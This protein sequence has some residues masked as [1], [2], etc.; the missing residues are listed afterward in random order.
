MGNTDFKNLKKRSATSIENLK[1]QVDKL[2]TKKD[3]GD[4][5][6]W[7]PK[8]DANGNAFT[9]IR[10]L[11]APSGEENDFVRLW[12]KGFKKN[13]RW[14]INNCLT[15]LGQDDP[16]VEYTNELW[17]TNEDEARKYKRKLTYI[18]NILVKRDPQTPENE[19]K[20]FLFKVGPKI[21]DKIQ[22]MV[23]PPDGSPEDP[24]N[25][26]D[27]WSGADFKFNITKQGEFNNYDTSVFMTPG[28][29]FPKLAHD[30]EALDEAIENVWK[31]QYSLEGEIA[32]DKFKTYD[33]LKSEF[34]R[35]MG[36][37][38]KSGN[39][40]PTT[41]A[42]KAPLESEDDDA[43]WDERPSVEQKVKESQ[44]PTVY[45]DDDFDEDFFRN[46]AKD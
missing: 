3:Y 41:R 7:Y 38:A 43:P 23:N 12:H 6:Y 31:S 17:K 24:C 15:T 34:N 8:Q 37:D 13:G 18:V 35:I 32:P 1:T 5:R 46:L 28:P 22:A 16:V 11:P 26:F 2:N 9:T 39:S 45:E 21:F 4:A 27:F 44:K 20:V 30:E 25:V 14:F 10:F 42:N 29:I 36:F 33:Q 40:N 19:G